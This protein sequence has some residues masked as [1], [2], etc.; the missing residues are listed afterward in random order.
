MMD[1]L[2]IVVSGLTLG[3]IYALIALGVVTPR[4]SREG[5]FVCGG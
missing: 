3:S 1:T 2:Q 4:K 5:E